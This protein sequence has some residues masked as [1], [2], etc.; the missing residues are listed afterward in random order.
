M[1]IMAQGADHDPGQ[2]FIV[3][4]GE[5]LAELCAEGVGLTQL[6]HFIARDWLRD[7]RL[8]TLFPHYRPADNG[9]FAVYPK[10]EYLPNRVR[11]LVEY[12]QSEMERQGESANHCW[13]ETL[14]T[15]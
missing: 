6:P 11:V 14:T 15:D 3:D 10:R 12:L 9:V 8:K 1:P 5:T 4:D 7:G 2:Q 13:T